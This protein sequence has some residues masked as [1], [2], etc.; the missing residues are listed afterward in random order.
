MKN[1]RKKMNNQRSVFIQNE[2]NL[3]RSVVLGI[4]HDQG[5]QLDIN[6]VSKLSLI[7]I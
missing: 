6:P 1:E 2:T 3:L 5:D 4:A 7:H